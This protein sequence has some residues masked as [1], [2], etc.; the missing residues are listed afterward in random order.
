MI[1]YKP[2]WVTLA[3][4]G[5]KK[6]DLYEL[7]SASTVA[8]MGKGEPVALKVIEQICLAYHCGIEDVVQI[9]PDEA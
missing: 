8:K 9:L 3:K 4:A 2:L 1:S 7:A 6:S 5:K